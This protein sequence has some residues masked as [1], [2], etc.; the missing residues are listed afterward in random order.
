[1]FFIFFSSNLLLY[2]KRLGTESKI[3]NS[4]NY[5]EDRGEN[6]RIL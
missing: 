4:M 5:I 6:T 1:M 2:V 3:K